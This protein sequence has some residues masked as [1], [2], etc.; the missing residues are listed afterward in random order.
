MGRKGF[1]I[2]TSEM[3]SVLVV[4]FVLAASARR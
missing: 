3:I 2:R 1:G 4:D